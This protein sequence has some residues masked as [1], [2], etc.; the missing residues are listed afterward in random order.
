[1][2]L[3]LCLCVEFLAAFFLSAATDTQS[4]HAQINTLDHPADMSFKLTDSP[5]IR[6]GIQYNVR[7]R[8]LCSSVCLI[9][10]ANSFS[11]P[12]TYGLIPLMALQ[13]APIRLAV[14][15]RTASWLSYWR[16]QEVNLTN[17][18]HLVLNW[19]GAWARMVH[20]LIIEE[21]TTIFLFLL[22]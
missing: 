17:H 12:R 1:M 16:R 6:A 7:V 18:S 9:I 13:F 5:W 2:E 11:L 14:F 4:R 20:E 22:A 3:W 8:R 10:L 21:K 19:S 15:L